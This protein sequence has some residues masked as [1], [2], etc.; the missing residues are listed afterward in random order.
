MRSRIIG[1]LAAVAALLGGS[2]LLP[3]S[4][5]QAPA[6]RAAAAGIAPDN[7]VDTSAIIDG[8]IY[9][10]D[11]N[12]GVESYLRQ[13]PANSVWSSSLNNGIVSEE[14]LYGPVRE[15]LS[16]GSLANGPVDIPET[17]IA[18]IGGPFLDNAT[19]LGSVD[20]PAGTWMVN[21]SAVFTRIAS[22]ASGATGTRP[23]LALRYN[24]TQGNPYGLSAG[25]LMGTEI[26]PTMSRELTTSAVET[27]TVTQP[28]QMSVFGFGYNDDQSAAGG[29]QITAKARI[30]LLRVGVASVG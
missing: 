9:Q 24:A 22:G 29:G 8:Q 18:K 30:T 15:K 3:A 5:V 11:I 25:T 26:S 2:A 21:T 4:A 10:S 19:L 28:T 16:W 12:D 7:S 17:A 13:T 6:P 20:L 27:I 14:K 1:T 23:Q